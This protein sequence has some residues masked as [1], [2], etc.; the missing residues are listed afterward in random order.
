MG[1]LKSLLTE[2]EKLT[3]V[4]QKEVKLQEEIDMT[5]NQRHLIATGPSEDQF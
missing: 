3:C 4:G 2:F 5:E 1:L